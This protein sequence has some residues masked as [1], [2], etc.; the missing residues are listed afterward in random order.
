MKLNVQKYILFLFILIFISSTVN[1]FSIVKLDSRVI[2]R[3]NGLCEIHD[4]LEIKDVDSNLIILDVIPVYDLIVKI[5]NKN[6]HFIHT[7]DKLNINLNNLN[8]TNNVNLEIIYLT[9]YFTTKKSRDWDINYFSIFKENIDHLIF[10]LPE[11][12]KIKYMSIDLEYISII[13]DKFIIVLNNI[14]NLNVKYNINSKKL[15][16][17]NKFNSKII[18]WVFLIIILIGLIVS[19]F[20]FNFKKKR[21]Q[22]YK[23]NKIKE[24]LLGLN[25]NEQKIILFLLDKE[26]VSQ[27]TLSLKLFLLKG[28]VSRNVKN[29]ESKEY[30]VIKNLSD[31]FKY[32]LLYSLT[33]NTQP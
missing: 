9:D 32:Q 14:D 8:N 2:V 31:S 26:G 3:D 12:T 5:D 22:N 18:L 4:V 7:L 20:L 15:N 33:I 19:K 16:S 17:R 13:D 10:E 6:V 21:L 25:E 28:T 30:V 11:N 24:L 1:A 23:S 27:K 29:L